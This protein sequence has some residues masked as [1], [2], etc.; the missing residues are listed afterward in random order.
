MGWGPPEAFALCCRPCSSWCLVLACSCFAFA[1]LCPVLPCFIVPYPLPYL[2]S[3]CLPGHA[4]S[5]L[6]VQVIKDAKGSEKAD[7]YAFGIL[8]WEL[9]TREEVGGSMPVS[10]RRH[11]AGRA[12]VI[13][14]GVGA[15]V[16]EIVVAVVLSVLDCLALLRC[17]RCCCCWRHVRFRDAVSVSSVLLQLA[18]WRC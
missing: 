4:L 13:V 12:V 2:A 11:H 17:Y 14:V 10:K 8:L 15:V 1:L 6:V 7:V 9:A 16:V 5:C 18:C 3:P